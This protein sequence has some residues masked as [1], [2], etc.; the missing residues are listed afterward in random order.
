[1][2]EN[3]TSGF[4]HWRKSKRSAKK[5]F[6]FGVYGRGKGRKL[7]NEGFSLNGA[8]ARNLSFMADVMQVGGKDLFGAMLGQSTFGLLAL[9]SKKKCILRL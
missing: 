6:L 8:S 1:M 4:S 5:I 7:R 9:L 2:H 3:E